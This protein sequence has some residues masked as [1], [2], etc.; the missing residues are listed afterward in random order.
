MVVP[1]HLLSLKR[2]LESY[3]YKMRVNA[4]Q[5]NTK[6]STSIRLQDQDLTLIL[7]VKGEDGEWR[8]LSLQDSKSLE[9]DAKD[10]NESE[11]SSGR[12]E[13]EGEEGDNPSQEDEAMGGGEDEVQEI[14]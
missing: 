2:H 12:E 7:A 1:D 4:R 11:D 13:E 6:I 9:E 14:A 3:A 8:Y 10:G 5:D